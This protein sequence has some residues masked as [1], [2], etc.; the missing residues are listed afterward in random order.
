MLP[1]DAR[2]RLGHSGLLIT[3]LKLDIEGGDTASSINWA[4]P[5]ISQVLIEF[6]HR[7]SPGGARDTE[8][9][10]AALQAEVF[11][12]SIARR[13][14]P[15]TCSARLKMLKFHQEHD[16]QADGDDHE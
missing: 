12:R 16:A 2:E 5:Q 6:H 4:D 7:L 9:A 10:A 11:A 15:N 13:P 14:V 3:L 8:A 1:A